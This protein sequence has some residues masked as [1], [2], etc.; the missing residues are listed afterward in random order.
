MDVFL[1]P[2]GSEVVV[3]SIDVV[4]L[5]DFMLGPGPDFRFI[6]QDQ[7]AA[8]IQLKMYI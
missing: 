8:T 2:A 6:T 1:S 4:F 7:Q 5:V 3:A